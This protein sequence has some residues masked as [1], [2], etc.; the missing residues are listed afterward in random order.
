MIKINGWLSRSK[1]GELYLHSNSYAESID[2]EDIP[3]YSED[4]ERYVSD[5]E[6]LLNEKL[7][8]EVTFENSPLKVE[9][10]FIPKFI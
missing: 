8:P 3:I 2:T 1:N 7:L 10:E 6:I 9:I 5:D 4:F